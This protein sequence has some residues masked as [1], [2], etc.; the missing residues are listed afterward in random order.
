MIIFPSSNPIFCFLVAAVNCRGILHKYSLLGITAVKSKRPELNLPT[1]YNVWYTVEPDVLPHLKF[2]RA[3]CKADGSCRLRW[4]FI[5]T[6]W[7]FRIT[8]C[9]L[10][11]IDFCR[12]KAN[13]NE[14]FCDVDRDVSRPPLRWKVIRIPP[15]PLLLNPTHKSSIHNWWFTSW[16]N[17]HSIRLL[18]R[19]IKR[20]VI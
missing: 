14:L 5:T 2:L 8:H 17:K 11:H 16:A 4:L 10:I 15:R 19:P 1:K 13:Y 7:L 20:F 6:T 12:F 3:W 9:H 18:S